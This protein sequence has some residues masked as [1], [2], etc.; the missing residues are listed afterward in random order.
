MLG[1]RHDLPTH[2]ART[3]G[4]DGR[5]LALDAAA[6]L[7]GEHGTEAVSVDD[8][9]AAAGLTRRAIYYHFP[10]KADLIH[11]WL[12]AEGPSTMARVIAAA[13]S[14]RSE[15]P[16]PIGRLIEAIGAA[17][18]SARFRGCPFL[19][20]VRERPRDRVVVRLARA[21]K[22]QGLEWLI[23]IAAR[24]GAPDPPRRAYQYMLLVDAMLS[25]GHL[26]SPDE[27]V[28][29]AKATLSAILAT[30]AAKAP[31]RPRARR[32]VATPA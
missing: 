18:R 7:F 11:A 19:N 10:A 20:T 29:T 5:Q 9:A 26:Y 27:L 17:V 16:H 8:V 3:A 23:G 4:L 2:M 28:A 15:H 24:E 21:S 30:D 12:R 14:T 31:A 6:R 22:A 25:T 1:L 32:R 13:S